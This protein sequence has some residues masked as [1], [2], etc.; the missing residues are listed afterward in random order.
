MA[1]AGIL[2]GY[3]EIMLEAGDIA[4]AR[5]AAAELAEIA[6]AAG[7]DYLSASASQ[8]A[9]ATLLAD[10]K[11]QEAL[12]DLRQAEVIWQQLDAAYSAART[13]LL[14][15]QACRELGDEDGA[16]LEIEAARQTFLRLGAAPDLDRV[17]KFR[18]PSAGA[19][20]GGLTGR[21]VQLLGLLATGKTNREIAEQLVISEK[22]VAR[23]VSN[24]FNKLG[25]SSRAGATAY[26]FKHHLV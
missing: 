26:A 12:A 23:H 13:R 2:P 1:R 18:V 4:A 5:A 24:I 14:I 3:L 17:P 11:A 16:E 19:G 7:S 8:A 9:G 22:T 21:E 10:G 6:V 25:V 20:A 15:G